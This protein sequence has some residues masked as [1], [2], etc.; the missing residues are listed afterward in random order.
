MKEK[1]KIFFRG[2]VSRPHSIC[3]CVKGR[4]ALS[5]NE[6]R[7]LQM[8]NSWFSKIT[9]VISPFNIEEKHSKKLPFFALKVFR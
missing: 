7:F 5:L 4:S 3:K 6:N 2:R 8:Q 9:S 1:V